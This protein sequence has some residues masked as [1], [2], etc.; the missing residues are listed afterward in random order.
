MLIVEVEV[1]VACVLKSSSMVG[2]LLSNK[3]RTIKEH[4][5]HFSFFPSNPAVFADSEYILGSYKSQHV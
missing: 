5:L 4:Y 2:T 3:T 1:L